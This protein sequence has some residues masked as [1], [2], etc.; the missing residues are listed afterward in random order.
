M[1]LRGGEVF[2]DSVSPEKVSG[3]F[4]PPVNFHPF[5]QEKRQAIIVIFPQDC[6]DFVEVKF[7]GSHDII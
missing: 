7:N 2:S 5:F 4:F 3:G 6:G 1:S